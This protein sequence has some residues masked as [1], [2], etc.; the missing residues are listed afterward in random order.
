MPPLPWRESRYNPDLPSLLRDGAV[1]L[2]DVA[3]LEHIGQHLQGT[4][5]AG[6]KRPVC[7]RATE[8]AAALTRAEGFIRRQD[9]GIGRPIAPNR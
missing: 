5:G 4:A 6:I 9:L 2:V 3:L 1:Q 7:E 8:H